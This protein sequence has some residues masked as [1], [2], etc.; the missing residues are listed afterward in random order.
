MKILVLVVA[1]FLVGI[2]CVR[3]QHQ[4]DEEGKRETAVDKKTE[5]EVLGMEIKLKHGITKPD[6]RLLK[7][8]LAE[9]Y[10]DSFE[11]SERAGGKDWAISHAGDPTVPYFSIDKD[12]RIF[13]RANIV[14]IEGYSVVRALTSN[15]VDEE[16]KP[17]KMRIKRLW[18]KKGNKW[19]LIA[20][21]KQPIE[22]DEDDKK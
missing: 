6:A 12:R 21:T 11:G 5:R 14:F 2:T 13:R 4:R 3:A 9:Y 10:A 22:E 7:Q 20:Q 15:D 18:T 16:K 19:L 1:I 17:H 8:I